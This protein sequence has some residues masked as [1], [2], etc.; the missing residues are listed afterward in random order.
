MSGTPPLVRAADV[1]HVQYAL[2]EIQRPN[3]PPDVKKE[4]LRRIDELERIYPRITE[5][6]KLG[7]PDRI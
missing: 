3:C 1:R 4:Q 6:T 2:R 7:H 5:E